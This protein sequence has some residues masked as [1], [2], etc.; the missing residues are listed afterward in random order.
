VP[1]GQSY[2]GKDN[3]RGARFS[4]PC[5]QSRRIVVDRFVPLLVSTHR[6]R[7]RRGEARRAE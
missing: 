1:L 6:G 3:G 5:Y 4:G 2:D 7:P